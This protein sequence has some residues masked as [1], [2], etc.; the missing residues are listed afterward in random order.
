M[1]SMNDL[2][3]QPYPVNKCSHFVCFIGSFGVY[4]SEIEGTSYFLIIDPDQGYL[5]L[6]GRIWTFE[7]LDRL[8]DAFEVDFSRDY[9]EQDWKEI[10][11]QFW[12]DDFHEAGDT[13]LC[14]SWNY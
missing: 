9:Q 14:S 7:E 6:Q 2:F 1:R 12:F 5:D 13:I 4:R 11:P 3:E 10:S 8:W